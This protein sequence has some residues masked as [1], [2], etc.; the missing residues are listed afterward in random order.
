MAPI[1]DQDFVVLDDKDIEG[2]NTAGLL[3]EPPEELQ[4][5]RRWLHPTDFSSD[6]SEFNKHL[7][8]HVAGT[9]RWIQETEQYQQ[10][11]KSS[12]HGA[13]WIK[14]VPGAGKSVVAA[15]LAS[16]LAEE[17]KVPVLRFFFRQIITTNKTPQSLLRDWMSQILEYSPLLQSKL[18][19][20]LQNNRS[21]ES[22]AFGELWD[23]LVTSLDALPR[24]Y[25]IADALDEMDMGNE[26]FL[27]QLIQLGKRRPSSIK[28]M[29]TSRPLPRIET[30]LNER[31]VL[32]IPL[33]LPIIDKDIAIY[34][35]SRLSAVDVPDEAKIEIEQ[36]I[37]SKSGGLFLY[38]RLMMDDL[39][40]SDKL[41]IYR[42]D[43]SLCK[44][45]TGLG[46]MYTAMLLDHSKR[47]G[48]SQELQLLILR[49]VTHSSR[50]LRLLEIASIVDFVRNTTNPD[51]VLT[52]TGVPQDTKSII[53]AGCGPLLE[54]LADE[55]VSVIHHS[56]TEFLLDPY[57]AVDGP[58]GFPR[59][60][61][62]TTHRTMALVS[63]DYLRSNRFNN[64]EISDSPPDPYAK[65]NGSAG[66]IRMK[67]PFLDYA[68]TYWHHHLSEYDEDDNEIDLHLDSLMEP[69]SKP[70]L[71]CLDLMGFDSRPG[72]VSPLHVAGTKGLHHYVAHLL[73]LGQDPNRLDPYSKTALH[74]AAGHG[75][76]RVVHILL[77]HGAANDLDDYAGLKPLHLAAS[78]N[79]A[80]VIKLL[81]EY[82]VDPFT[83]KTKENPGNW[84]GNAPR[85]T[86]DTPVQYACIF[87]HTE[88]VRVF[89]PYLDSYGLSKALCWAT[90]HGRTDVVLAILE[91]PVVDVN[92]IIDGKTPIH[93][94]AHARDIQ[95]MR[96]LL[97]LGAD[98]NIKCNADFG[99]H[100]IRA[101]SLN[102]EPK[103]SPLHVYATSCRRG[104]TDASLSDTLRGFQ[105]LLE[106]GCDV[107][108][109]DESGLTPFHCLLG[110]GG[111]RFEKSYR[112]PELLLF[113]L[114]NG[115]KATATKD[116][117]QPLH[118][119]EGE[120]ES[121]IDLLVTHG[122]DVNGRD[123]DGRT[124]LFKAI[125]LYH[126]TNF[127][128]LLRHSADVNI[129]DKDGNTPLH[130]AITQAPVSNSK[131]KMLLSHGA[132]PN[133]Q[134]SNGETPLHALCRYITLD[135]TVIL[136]LFLEAKADLEA[137][138]DAGLTVL[139]KAVTNNSKL[140]YIKS[141]IEAGARV[142]ARDLKG[143]SALHLACQHI[144]TAVPLIRALIEAGA[145]PT[146]KD[147]AGNTILH[148]AA[149]SPPDYYQMEQ[150]LLLETILDL[151][152]SP[153]S[154]NNS[155]Q[156][157]FYIAA[158][159]QR[160]RLN[161]MYK[162]DPYDFLLGPRCNS[163]VN[164]HDNMGIRPIHLAA[165]LSEVQFLRLI[166]E[167][168][169]LLAVTVEGQSVLQIAARARQSNIVGIILNLLKDLGK[170]SL[171][172][173]V[174]K[175]GRTA[176]HY[177]V[178]SGRL[179]S[180]NL[181]LEAGADVNLKDRKN[182]TPLDM[183]SQFKTEDFHW[184]H[185]LSPDEVYIDAAYVLLTD[186]RRPRNTFPYNST[187]FSAM[188]SENRTAGI[189]RIV[190]SLV[191]H[192]ADVSFLASSG[193]SKSYCVPSN[194][195]T[196]EFASDDEALV[197]ELLSIAENLG[198]KE[199]TEEESNFRFRGPWYEFKERYA[200]LRPQA[201]TD[202][203]RGIVKEGE[204]NIEIFHQLLKTEN[205][206]GIEQMQRLG[207]DL[208]TPDLH[209]ESCLTTLAKWGYA[210]LLEQ[211]GAKASMIDEPWLTEIEKNNINWG[212]PGRLRPILHVAC[213]R[214]L[215]NFDVLKVLIE[216]LGVNINCKS[217]KEGNRTALH[218]L[219]E[220]QH[221]WQAG[222]LEYLIGKGADIEIKDDDGFSPLHIAAFK[223]KKRAVEILLAKGADPNVLDSNSQSCLNKAG[224]NS[225]IVHLLIRYGA[226]ISAG[227][228][229]FIFSAIE[230]MDLATVDLVIEMKAN[231]NIR[232]TPDEE[233]E[234][235]EGH[236]MDFFAARRR[237][238]V[239]DISEKSSAIHFAAQKKF[240]TAESRP[241]MIPIIK[242]LLRGGADPMLPYNKA[243]DLIL[244]EI[245]ESEGII[246]P[247]LEAPNVDLE[248]RDCKGRTPL[249]AACVTP[250]G[251]QILGQVW[252]FPRLYSAELLFQ[253]GVDISARDNNG[254]NV[255]H[256]L[257]Q[258]D[259]RSDSHRKSIKPIFEVF[260]S[261]SQGT[262][263]ATQKDAAGWTPLHYALKNGAL[264]AVG[265]LL[266]KGAD[267]DMPDPDG[268]TVLHHLCA[269]LTDNPLAFSLLNE[270][271]SLGLDIN[272]LNK[273]GQPP[274]F[275]YFSEN[276]TYLEYLPELLETGADLKTKDNKG[277]GLLHV[278]A[279]KPYELSQ[280][281]ARFTETGQNP[282]VEIFKWLMEKGLGMDEDSEQRTP[283]DVAA[284]SENPGI[285]ELF[286]RTT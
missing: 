247:F 44:L 1:E 130:V 142:D 3:P 94:A 199:S 215:P 30:A 23:N 158:G 257:L 249:L 6:S 59:I 271:L 188:G 89:I 76:H 241:K 240:N 171:V 36:S 223:G 31:S 272:A 128:A 276:S 22:V 175:E 81:L 140:S 218:I 71:S 161:T 137:K 117:S 24:V 19:E 67:Y 281:E 270:F 5:I 179:E 109:F 253:K 68:I 32:E 145:D 150:L 260:L 35:R 255:L 112:S 230:S 262:A 266:E 182:C 119:V 273:L 282:D 200:R 52:A 286:K 17:E 147:F 132:N 37:R 173:N 248:A 259:D 143:K 284:A 224:S 42:I 10:W 165:T 120:A 236:E 126:E 8:S 100:G 113:L 190:R 157:P 93:I 45:P 217:K 26:P 256:H 85:S 12:H 278:I 198:V 250:D 51:L 129:Q 202:L 50:P 104:L 74:H 181:L 15:H 46:D 135:D 209:G 63:I 205:E 146:T 213:E 86:G 58:D 39:T 48:V 201:V 4:R 168:A 70:F 21:L 118:L 229:P 210:S 18:K 55:T 222:G 69:N 219:A 56:F 80:A 83:Q 220:S 264:W 49:F 206:L 149:R 191:D 61:F 33:R 170:P 267:P 64:Y 16:Q 193:L 116:G 90:G 285:L 96:K 169:D 246:E 141:L 258:N 123:A 105:M 254:R 160:C 283:L 154:R 274:I 7:A 203:L 187:S 9:G 106:A 227:K 163:D 75:H 139:L 177:A 60:D 72:R 66:I 92:K 20:L 245:C 261:Q 110:G 239:K 185:P 263:L 228:K 232:P 265:V 111:G 125:T 156:T 176:L 162:T 97:D 101:I 28:V 268:N 214:L 82:G 151:G 47:S 195:I 167:G 103:S 88:S 54:I 2:F 40:D 133:A 244:H 280:N 107:N 166:D 127:T 251:W 234:H 196:L 269:Q 208:I 242:S 186:Y 122:G 194:L 237:L 131:I 41:R 27:R 65:P 277:Q 238:R 226:D 178:K 197:D 192:G 155:G 231:L 57:R 183:C 108:G 144:Q 115:A 34:V 252:T 180:V 73:Q 38:A 14:A 25:C 216:K 79:H 204:N 184:S 136:P 152:V 84:C 91:S 77:E 124:P 134:N 11:I 29:M 233:E 53:R 138:T 207:A 153:S 43:D 212:V 164:G 114:G 174:D 172:D 243:G 78:N 211:V 98:T 189:R 121:I 87:G 95:S 275:K 225:A 235:I 62:A 221:W 102:N 159:M 279:K 13:L 148:Q 99:N